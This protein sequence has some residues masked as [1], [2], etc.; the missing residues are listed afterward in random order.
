MGE[1]ESVGEQYLVRERQKVSQRA[2]GDL[3]RR[4]DQEKK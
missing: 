2:T 3:K 1:C 4:E